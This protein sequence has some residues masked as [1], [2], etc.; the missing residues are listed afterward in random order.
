MHSNG[1]FC[2]MHSIKGIDTK[3]TNFCG[4]LAV[5]CNLGLLGFFFLYR[6]IEYLMPTILIAFFYIL[7]LILKYNLFGILIL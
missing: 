4:M 3:K 5:L 2:V 7:V 6:I 1:H